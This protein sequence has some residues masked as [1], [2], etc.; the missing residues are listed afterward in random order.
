M[1]S[2]KISRKRLDAIRA[3]APTFGYKSRPISIQARLRA[4]TRKVRNDIQEHHS[5]VFVLLEEAVRTILSFENY[6]HSKTDDDRSVVPFKLL[7][8]RVRADL[9]AIHQ[10]LELGQETSA[11]AVARVFLEDIELAMAAAIDPEFSIE[12]MDASAEDSFWSKRVAY[13]KIYPLV[14]KFLTLG[15]QDKQ[16]AQDHIQQHRELKTFLSAHVH[17]SF[18]SAFS[19][20][21]PPVLDRPGLFANRPLGWFGEASAKLC[22]Y[23]AD[24]IHVFSA[25]CINM[26][27]RPD[28]P[29]ALAGYKPD[30]SLAAFLAPAHSLQILKVRYFSRLHQ[31]YERRSQEWNTAAFGKADET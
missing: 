23:L 6:Q 13:G 14:S 29:P 25:C 12:Y 3:K 26:F 9:V 15:A 8:S 28:P 5:A 19:T 4:S 16:N 11:L 24:E 31:D 10:L 21:L 27:V 18:H 20:V 30:K 1:S 22:L 7:V 2:L 17:P